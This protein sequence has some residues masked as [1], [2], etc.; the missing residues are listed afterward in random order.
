MTDKNTI[1]I[2][3]KLNVKQIVMLED[4]FKIE[5]DPNCLDDFELL[6]A[7]VELNQ[8]NTLIYPKIVDLMFSPEIKKAIENHFKTA[9]G[10]CKISHISGAVEAVMKQLAN[11]NEDVKNS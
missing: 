5:V 11:T 2:P 10:K 6:E 3:D 8:G 9:Y 1:V 7:M 4:G